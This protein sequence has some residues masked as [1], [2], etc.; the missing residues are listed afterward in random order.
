MKKI[1]DLQK[2]LDGMVAT[3]Y[4]SPEE[5]QKLIELKKAELERGISLA[6]NLKKAGNDPET[7]S[8]TRERLLDNQN[9][10]KGMSVFH[11]S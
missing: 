10:K 6:N 7:I 5:V 11:W 9:L 8:K 2:K 3:K 1:V 4:K